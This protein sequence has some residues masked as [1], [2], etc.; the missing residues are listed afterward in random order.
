MKLLVIN[1]LLLIM[2]L[3]DARELDGADDIVVA[4]GCKSVAAIRR[5]CSAACPAVA[6][7]CTA[8]VKRVTAAVA[9]AVVLDMMASTPPR[10]R[11][12]PERG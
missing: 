6:A 5:A 11:G 8:R 7:S 4:C 2:L 1:L 10:L 3:L 12:W 9:E